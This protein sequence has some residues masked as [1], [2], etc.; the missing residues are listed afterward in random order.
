[1]KFAIY[2]TSKTDSGNHNGFQVVNII[3][4][5]NAVSYTHLTLP[6]ILLV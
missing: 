1:M 6:T 5:N 2:D 4:T 3:C